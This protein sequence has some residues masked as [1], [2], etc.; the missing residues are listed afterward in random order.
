[1]AHVNAAG[2]AGARTASNLLFM[3]IPVYRGGGDL[4]FQQIQ[5]FL[6][7]FPVSLFF[8]VQ[9]HLLARLS[10]RRFPNEIRPDV[11]RVLHSKIPLLAGAEQTR[12]KCRL[13]ALATACLA[14]C[15]RC[16]TTQSS[17]G[18]IS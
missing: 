6:P 10:I 13:I 2:N 14:S 5:A 1:M 8:F 15:V 3:R 16:T 4:N 18:P 12:S 17:D 7:F 9:F 11:R